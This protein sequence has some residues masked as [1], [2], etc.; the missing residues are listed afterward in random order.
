[1][2][3]GGRDG[4][5][6]RVDGRDVWRRVERLEVTAPPPPGGAGVPLPAARQVEAVDLGQVGQQQLQLG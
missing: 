4:E 5:K 3:Q 1:M 2:I 6:E